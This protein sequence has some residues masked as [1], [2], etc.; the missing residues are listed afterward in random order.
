M[1][2]ELDFCPFKPLTGMRGLGNKPFYGE[3]AA[4]DLIDKPPL[5]P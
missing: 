1:N 3:M 4:T 5:L 2:S